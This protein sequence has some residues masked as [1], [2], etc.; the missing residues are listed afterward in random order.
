M[1]GRRQLARAASSLLAF[2]LCALVAFALCAACA[3]GASAQ[4]MRFAVI[5]DFGSTT[6]GRK[7][8]QDLPRAERLVAE[9]VR[10]WDPAFILTL[11]DNNY[12]CG[13]ASTLNQ[14]VGQFYCDFIH[15]PGAPPGQVC[16][17]RAAR[18]RQNRFFP[19]LG[20][21][22]YYTPNA[23]PH[24]AYFSELPGNRRYYDF[25]QGPVH[26]FALNSESKEACGDIEEGQEKKNCAGGGCTFEP[27]GADPDSKQ[28]A[29]LRERM[30]A[31]KSEWKV[32]FFHRPPY[33]CGAKQ[34]APWMRWPFEEWG[35]S[36]VLS[37][38][39]HVYERIVRKASPNFPYFVNG[40][41]GT[42]LSGCRKADI[43][44]NLPPAE[45][46]AFHVEDLHGAILVE[47][48]P[49]ELTIQFHSVSPQG[50]PKLEDTCRLT[51]TPR[52]Q[53]LKCEK[54]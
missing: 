30:R 18:D 36:A 52:G 45:F 7:G 40:V 48:T 39:R 9:M 44:V 11:G 27:D 31:S 1:R 32:V 3:G 51:R 33:S 43:P 54:G 20:N 14:N 50:T 47:A 46:D 42:E 8:G 22:D 13:A 10:G 38:H 35:A 12:E 21:H 15:N 25:V 28:A 53:T 23:A 6:Q 5:G 37:G 26:F 17:G 49:Q 41:G 19:T 2:A 4:K 16:Q 24:L 29:W 34:A